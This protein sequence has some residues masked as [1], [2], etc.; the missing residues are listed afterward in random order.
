MNAVIYA[1]YSCHSQT[2]QSIEGQLRDCYAYAER[3][4]LTV[5]SEYIDRAISG[6]TDDRP[7]FLRMIDDAP[8]KQFER[9][10]VWKLDRFARNRYDSALY[11]HKLKQYDV[12]VISVMENVGEG[13]E[14][15]LLEALLEATAEYYSLDLR[16]KIKRGQRENIAKGR[17]CGGTIPYGYK[18]VDGKLVADEVKAPVI[19]YVFEQYAAG[20]PMREIIDELTRRGIRSSRGTPLNYNTFSRALVNPVYIGKYR[21]NGQTVPGLSEALVDEDTFNRVQ[22]NVTRRAHAPAAGTGNVDYLL[23]GKLFCGFCGRAMVGECGRSKSGKTYHYYACA[24]KK[25]RH[26]CRKRNERKEAL[27]NHV[28]SRTVR[29]VLHPDVLPRIA[30]AVFDAQTRDAAG[31]TI[32]ELERTIK[33]LDRDIAKLVDA[34]ISAPKAAHAHIYDK[35]EQLGKQKEAAEADLARERLRISSLPTYDDVL[36]FIR[37]FTAGTPDDPSFCKSLI[38]TFINSV[39]IFDDRIV[40]LYNTDD[41]PTAPQPSTDLTHLTT[42]VPLDSLSVPPNAPPDVSNVSKI[43]SCSTVIAPGSPS[44]MKS[45]PKLIFIGNRFG[46]LLY[47]PR[48]SKA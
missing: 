41:H 19:R 20:T 14:S 30:R 10:L 33:R 48:H 36:A 13:D 44:S 18:S 40:I 12:R 35:M 11:K 25:K 38:A 47:N 2:E 28:I 42:L 26:T 43:I 23:Q 21:Y 8:K 7:S 9:I 24:N 6:T 45:E 4:N 34:L 31:D 17:F 22:A 3:N 27:E 46:L 1:R 29:H 37:A 15:I 5:I 39:Y 16:K 32:P